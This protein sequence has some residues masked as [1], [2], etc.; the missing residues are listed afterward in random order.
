MI[1]IQE[2]GFETFEPEARGLMGGLLEEINI[3]TPHRPD[4]AGYRRLADLGAVKVITVRDAGVLCGYFLLLL[5]PNLNC[6]GENMAIGAA[7]YVHPS[8]RK[9]TNIGSNLISFGEAVAKKAGAETIMIASPMQNPIDSLLARKHYAPQ[10]L[11][12]G[13]RL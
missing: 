2:E 8:Y 1:T 10:E 11:M 9:G 12:F 13:R 3:I 7:L 6:A 4:W 5:T